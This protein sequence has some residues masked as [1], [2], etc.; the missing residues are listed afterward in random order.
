MPESLAF[1]K[2]RAVKTISA[3]NQVAN[4]WTWSELSPAQ[5]QT[6]LDALAGNQLA[7]PPVLGQE[8]IV[9]TAEQTMLTARSAWDGGLDKLHAW[10]VLAV[11]S[12]KNSYRNDPAKLALVSGLSASESSRD[13]VVA[14]ALA[15]ATAW[16]STDANWVPKAGV[17]LAAFKAQREASNEAD[18]KAY[19][20]AHSAWSSAAGTQRMMAAAL[21]DRNE[22][23]YASAVLVFPAGTPD[24]D[25]IRTTIPTTYS[26]PPPKAKPAPAPAP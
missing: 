14:E 17:T 24:G 11:G 15:L 1:I 3:A 16:E 19:A 23:W 4:V 2:D 12:L 22:G 25:M 7:K 8:S 20:A 26:P 10:T 18:R 21:E 13:G 5:H 9:G 6:Q